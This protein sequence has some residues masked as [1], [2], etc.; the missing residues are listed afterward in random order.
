MPQ[1]LEPTSQLPVL[2][3]SVGGFGL[4]VAKFLVT[5]RT[6]VEELVVTDDT[7][8][9]PEVWPHA[10]MHLIAS[11][12]PVHHICDLLNELSHGWRT[13]FVPLVADSKR[14]Q[15][16]PVT[17]P[18]G[19]SCWACWVRRSRQHAAWP[20]EYSA[21]LEYYA[22]HPQAGPQGYLEPFALMAAVRLSETI[23]ALDRSTA[24]AG[25]VWQIDMITREITTS[26]V[27]GV[28]DCPWCGLGQ[29]PRTRSFA[30]IQSHLADLWTSPE[31]G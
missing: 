19:G 20:K 11:W 7:I 28:H 23:D 31:V 16:G 8:P 24:T 4:A 10:R 9:L 15:L 18:G 27:V 22:S 29:S 6:D 17:I 12:R 3:L 21:L 13:P 26:M 30:G 14:L 5:L 25:E 2:L 1:M